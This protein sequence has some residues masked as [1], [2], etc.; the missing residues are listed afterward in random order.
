MKTSQTLTPRGRVLLWIWAAVIGAA[1]AVI[2][3]LAAR[4]FETSVRIASIALATWFPLLVTLLGNRVL[5]RQPR[6]AI[7]WMLLGFGFASIVEF[8]FQLMIATE[9]VSPSF[10]DYLALMMVRTSGL[11]LA[12]YLLVLVPYI[13]PTG[14][15]L[16][17]RQARVPW[18]GGVMLVVTT[19]LA[20]FTEEIG[21]Y[22]P[23]PGQ[24]WTINNPIGFLPPLVLEVTSGL[25]LFVIF[26]TAVGGAVS[27]TA[28]YRRSSEVTRAQIRWVLLSTVVVVAVL[29]IIALTDSSRT[30]VG[31]LLVQAALTSV[32]LAIT[33]AITRYRLFEIDRIISRTV[34]YAAIVAV[35]GVVFAAG[36]VWLPTAL[37]L[38]DSPLLVA[39]TTLLVAALFNPLR[40]RVQRVVDERFNRSHIEAQRVAEQFAARLRQT[41]TV[42]ELIRIWMRTVDEALS[43]ETSGVWISAPDA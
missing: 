30:F 10:S 20:I 34:A 16:T 6:N 2:F 1:S 5:I 37:D 32:P 25:S 14:H 17:R 35:L 24:D 26:A 41:H 4:D 27:L 31:G 9:P 33:I 29:V 8:S 18:A 7:G 12:V 39:G 38:G 13:F 28:R 40:N 22:F 21:P 36:V 15:F 19:L 43:P 11:M 3:V 42:D 23:A